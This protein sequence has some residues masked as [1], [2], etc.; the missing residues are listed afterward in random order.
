MAESVWDLQMALEEIGSGLTIRVGTIADVIKDL[1]EG[2]RKSES[3][4]VFGLWMTSEEGVEEKQEENSV[5]RALQAEG[6]HFKL[7]VD[8][9]YLIDE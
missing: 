2:F 5:R 7:W 3:T 6:K 9:K 1:L 8:E 4:E